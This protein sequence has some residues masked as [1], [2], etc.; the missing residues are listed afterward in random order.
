MAQGIGK[1]QIASALNFVFG[2]ATQDT[3][4]GV[5]FIGLSVGDSG[6]DGQSG[7][8]ATGTGYAR[9]ATTAVSWND[10]TDATPSVVSNA[11]TIQFPNA[12]ED[13]SGGASFTHFTVWTT[14]TG[15]AEVDYIGRGLLDTALP[16]LDGRDPSFPPGALNMTGSEPT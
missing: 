1:R 16:V 7:A 9:V 6:D 12:G 15:T 8:E 10:A 3:P 4:A 11:S 13:W 2:G 14:L 5:V